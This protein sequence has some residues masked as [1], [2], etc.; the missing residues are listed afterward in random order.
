M[1][2][3]KEGQEVVC[4]TDEF[5]NVCDCGGFTFSPVVENGIYHIDRY[6]P[7]SD[8]FV[9]LKD[10]GGDHCWDQ[11]GFELMEEMDSDINVLVDE[12]KTQR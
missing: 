12:F 5:D 2:R 10:G 7:D 6:H 3:F 8:R 4:T 1:K 9:Y 11:W